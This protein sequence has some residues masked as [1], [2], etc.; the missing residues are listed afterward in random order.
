MIVFGVTAQFWTPWVTSSAHWY[1]WCSPV[2]VCH[3][4]KTPG[5]PTPHLLTHSTPTEFPINQFF[6][7]VW[8]SLIPFISYFEPV[9]GFVPS[10]QCGG[11]GSPGNSGGRPWHRHH[12]LV[13]TDC[14]SRNCTKEGWHAFHPNS[15]DAQAHLCIDLLERQGQWG[16]ISKIDEMSWQIKKKKKSQW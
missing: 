5:I 3:I 1:Q 12:H 10:P 11:V 4:K 16:E 8:E 13:C 15:R 2:Q 14:A 7:T 6:S 9:W